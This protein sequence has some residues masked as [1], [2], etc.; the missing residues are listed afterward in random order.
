MHSFESPAQKVL[1][2]SRFPAKIEKCFLTYFGAYLCLRLRQSLTHKQNKVL[3]QTVNFASMSKYGWLNPL[4]YA[5]QLAKQ[6]TLLEKKSQ[7]KFKNPITQKITMTAKKSIPIG[8]GKRLIMN[9][10]KYMIL[11]NS[12]RFRFI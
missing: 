5:F 7:A 6:V 11:M 3:F 9:D 4:P 2:I 8:T 10:S 1:L 12:N